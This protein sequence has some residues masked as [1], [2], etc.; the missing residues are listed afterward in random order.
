MALRSELEASI[1][2]QITLLTVM[3]TTTIAVLGFAIQKKITN[4]LNKTSASQLG[5]VTSAL[6]IYL[7]FSNYTSHNLVFSILYVC[8]KIALQ[9]QD[10]K[11]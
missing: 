4:F 7:H 10:T 5:V 11:A 6:S 1:N 2:N 8:A 3:Y 9:L